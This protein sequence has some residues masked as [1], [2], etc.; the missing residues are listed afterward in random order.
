MVCTYNR[1]DMLLRCVRL[2]L[3]QTRPPLEI[4][5]VDASDGWESSVKAVTDLVATASPT[6]RLVYE[7]AVVRSTTHQR[8]QAL[9]HVTADI[10]FAIDDDSLMTPDCAAGVLDVYERDVAGRI[11]GVGIIGTPTPP[12][13]QPVQAPVE[14]P[15]RVGWLKAA[16][17][18]QLDMDR[19]FVPYFP[20]DRLDQGEIDVDGRKYWTVR[21][22]NGFRMTFRTELGRKV[23]WCEALLFYALH[24]DADFSYRL[25]RLGLLVMA[26]T[27]RV[28]HCQAPGGRLPRAVV[29]RLRVLNLAALHRVYSPNLAS[30]RRRILAT[31]SRA[32]LLYLFLDLVKRRFSLP[33]VRAYLWG[34]ARAWS[35]L[36][37]PAATFQDEFQTEV[38]ALVGAR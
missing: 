10:V 14:P 12:D 24:E 9:A 36:S 23:A 13:E 29:D 17:N 8:N 28:C 33:T 19:R 35:I 15:A 5:I 18:R 20:G 2:T 6:V 21:L 25:S 1:P 38:R 11:A 16:L 32:A 30:S 37:A 31:Y 22:L 7:R 26:P 3:T 27:G 34:I 4:V